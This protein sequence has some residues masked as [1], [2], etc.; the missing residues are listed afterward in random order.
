V[1]LGLALRQLATGT[2]PASGSR[3]EERGS[4]A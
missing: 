3:H 4:T 1:L 2:V